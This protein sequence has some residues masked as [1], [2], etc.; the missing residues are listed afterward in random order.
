MK[1]ENTVLN[2]SNVLESS[3][4]VCRAIRVLGQI[5]NI[6][7]RIERLIVNSDHHKTPLLSIKATVARVR[8]WLELVRLDRD[9]LIIL[10]MSGF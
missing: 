4:N 7:H 2:S 1:H 5:R 3:A 9:P 6:F 10:K 8:D